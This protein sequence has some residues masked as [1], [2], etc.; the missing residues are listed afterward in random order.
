MRIME[1]Y[2]FSGSQ[3][4]VFW[5]HASLNVLPKNTLDD[6]MSAGQRDVTEVPCSRTGG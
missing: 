1:E 5:F 6:D 2:I 3:C 4:K